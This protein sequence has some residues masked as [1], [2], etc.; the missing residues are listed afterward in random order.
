M[1]LPSESGALDALAELALCT[2]S[3]PGVQ[4]FDASQVVR[5][6]LKEALRMLFVGAQVGA[7]SAEQAAHAKSSGLV[8]LPEVSSL[9]ADP[10][11][12]Q[13]PSGTEVQNR[14]LSVRLELRI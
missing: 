9:V 5:V 1:C 13:Y 11:A 12:F 2:R 14:F 7:G 3:I 6:S 4:I 8:V 10:V